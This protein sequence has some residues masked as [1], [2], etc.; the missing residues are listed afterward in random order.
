M[1][2]LI[3]RANFGQPIALKFAV[4][5]FADVARQGTC[6]LDHVAEAAGLHGVG[7]QFIEHEVSSGIFY[8]PNSMARFT[9]LI[10]SE[11]PFARR[12][13]LALDN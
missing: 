13:I 8:G 2:D 6:R 4:V 3:Q 11:P 9:E 1:H 10:V 5:I 12:T 7:S